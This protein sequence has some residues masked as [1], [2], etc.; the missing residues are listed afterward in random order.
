MTEMPSSRVDTNITVLGPMSQSVACLRWSVSTC[1][2]ITDQ[3]E[4]QHIIQTLALKQRFRG[5]QYGH[6][7]RVE[8]LV[9][10]RGCETSGTLL[11]HHSSAQ[12]PHQGWKH[13]GTESLWQSINQSSLSII[14]NEACCRVVCEMLSNM[15]NPCRGQRCSGATT[16]S[17]QLIWDV[18]GQGLV[19]IKAEDLV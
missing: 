12:Q 16:S 1:I 10:S 11:T 8:E 14:T 6:K 18:Q 5:G 13:A 17:D 7:S 15:D 4:R 3:Q 9:Q 19:E 2:F